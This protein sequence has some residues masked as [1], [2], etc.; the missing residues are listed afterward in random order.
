[1]KKNYPY[2]NCVAFTE[3]NLKK[4]KVI[5]GQNAYEHIR[6]LEYKCEGR[7]KRWEV[8]LPLG[9]TVSGP[10]P[11]REIK[12]NG[13]ICQ[14]ASQEDID[15]A[16][17]VKKW[18]DLES[19]GTLMIADRRIKDNKFAS[20]QLKPSVKFNGERYEVGLL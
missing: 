1:M 17:V 18:W 5:L 15:Q 16:E 12:L 7:N 2:L 14:L 9:W 19:Y 10:L 11:T 8:R 20:E 13:S 6:P 3:I 4:V